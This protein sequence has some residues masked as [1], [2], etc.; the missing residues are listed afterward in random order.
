MPTPIE[1]EINS[2]LKEFGSPLHVAEHLLERWR[3]NLLSDEEQF[4]C[5]Q[6]MIAAGLY[7]PFFQHIGYLLESDRK[8]PWAQ[9]AEAIGRS[10]IKPDSHMLDALFAGAR[11]Q[12]SEAELLLSCQLDIWDRRFAGRRAELRGEHA[13]NVEARKAQ[14]LEKLQFMRANRLL[15]QEAAILE[16]LRRIFP[17]DEAFAAEQKKFELRWARELI[18]NLSSRL[19]PS[20]D[21]N[22][23][24]A[25]LSAEELNA[26]ELLVKRAVELA[27]ANPAHAHDLAICL[28]FMD[29]NAEAVDL[30]V[31]A[32]DGSGSGAGD[33]AR[34]WLRLEL[35]LKARRFVTA[36]DEASRLELAYSGDPEAPFAIVYARAQALWGLG[37]AETAIAMMESLVRVRPQYKSA[38]SLLMEWT[39][40]NP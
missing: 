17:D 6:F 22:W 14:L 11:Q 12:E 18:A 39:E 4:D 9:L 35:L 37:Q 23:K 10:Q 28:H 34:D 1:S 8:I 13:V 2:L 36:L 33:R 31:P 26:K 32:P 29:F 7:A 38:Q 25:H 21:L 5:A 3:H 40:G 27:K 19:D 30:L 15:E 20:G 24:A 16:E